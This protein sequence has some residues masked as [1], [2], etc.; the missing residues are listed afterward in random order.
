MEKAMAS[1]SGRN[2]EPGMPFMVNAGANTAKM[3]KQDQQLGKGDLF[4]RIP[5]RQRFGLAHVQ[6]CWCMFSIVTVVSSTNIP[7]ASDRPLKVIILMV[8]PEEL[9]GTTPRK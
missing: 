6:R 2:S 1:A 9:A 8:C 5:Y 7:I 4:T 3:H